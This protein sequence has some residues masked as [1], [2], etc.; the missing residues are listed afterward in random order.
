MYY[1]TN[2]WLTQEQKLLFREHIKLRKLKTQERAS[3]KHVPHSFINAQ[4]STEYLSPILIR[5]V[6]Y[7]AFQASQKQWRAGING[8]GDELSCIFGFAEHPAKIRSR[9]NENRQKKTEKKFFI[10]AAPPFDESLY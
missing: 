8:N 9:A 10:F 3:V 2:A 5:V 6:Q 4:R 7:S 1:V